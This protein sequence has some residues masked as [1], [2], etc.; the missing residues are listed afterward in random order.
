[1]NVYNIL[2]EKYKSLSNLRVDE[3][4]ISVEKQTN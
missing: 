1:M 2:V 3:I 4:M